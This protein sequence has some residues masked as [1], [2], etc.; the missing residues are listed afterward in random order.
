[1]KYI[2]LINRFWSLNAVEPFGRTD[3]TVYLYLLNQCN[4]RHWQNPFTITL[5]QIEVAV[6]VT[7]KTVSESLKR[8]EKRGLLTTKSHRY[9]ST[10]V[11][12]AD[13]DSLFRSHPEATFSP[14]SGP[15]SGPHQSHF[16]THIKRVKNINDKLLK[17]HSIECKKSESEIKNN[18]RQELSLISEEDFTH[19]P[20]HKGAPIPEEE[21][22]NDSGQ[23]AGAAGG[24]EIRHGRVRRVPPLL[25]HG[26][27][28]VVRPLF[29]N[30]YC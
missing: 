26:Q 27:N 15:L 20:G 24:C 5:H 1:M 3:S 29:F 13:S 2:N 7:R 23:E 8:L 25:L 22:K 28:L 17:K 9:L 19:H 18:P 14:T 6:N 30:N 21:L 16:T 12:L 11:I 10:T 4:L